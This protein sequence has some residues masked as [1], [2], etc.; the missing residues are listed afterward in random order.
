MDCNKERKKADMKLNIKELSFEPRKVEIKWWQW[1]IGIG[2]ATVV[3]F[4]NAISKFL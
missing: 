1:L 4:K 2:I 3:I